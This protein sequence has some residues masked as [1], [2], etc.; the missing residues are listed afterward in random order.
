MTKNLNRA[1]NDCILSPAKRD[2]R[3]TRWYFICG[4]ELD[5]PRIAF[6]KGRLFSKKCYD[7]II[8]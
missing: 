4:D 3:P 2:S 1:L 6:A 7:P 8:I 5:L